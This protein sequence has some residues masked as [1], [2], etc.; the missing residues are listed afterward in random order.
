MD[1]TIELVP[2]FVPNSKAP[3][4][5]KILELNELQLQLQELIGNNRI[6]PSVSPWGAP[7]LFV[8][9]K[10]NTLSLCIDYHQLNK[11]TIK[12]RYP[13]PHIDDMFD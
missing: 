4:R 2:G 13:L 7:M 11:M 8:K 6:R 10:D 5:M 3:Y 12:N 9:K 1:F